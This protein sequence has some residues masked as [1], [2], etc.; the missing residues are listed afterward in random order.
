MSADLAS[1]KEV[2][3]QVMHLCCNLAYVAK[4]CLYADAT[5]G[6]Y[7]NT[8]AHADLW[9]GPGAAKVAI[10][11]FFSDPTDKTEVHF[12]YLVSV[13]LL[14]YLAWHTCHDP[15]PLLVALTLLVSM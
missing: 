13:T 10:K 9:C 4:S 8:A 1:P 14:V 6:S 3:D 11:H 2:L 15:A 12:L 7:E 5:S